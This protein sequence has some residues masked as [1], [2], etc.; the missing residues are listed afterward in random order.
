MAPGSIAMPGRIAAYVSLSGV[1]RR[2]VAPESDLIEDRACDASAA[3]RPEAVRG[4]HDLGAVRQFQAVGRLALYQAVQQWHLLEICPGVVQH[5][6]GLL[7]VHRE[8]EDAR[9]LAGAQQRRVVH[10]GRPCTPLSSEAMESL[11]PRRPATAHSSRTRRSGGSRSATLRNSCTSRAVIGIAERSLQ[12]GAPDVPR[13]AVKPPTEQMGILHRVGD[14]DHAAVP[15]ASLA[16][17]VRA[18]HHQ[19]G[20]PAPSW[21]GWRRWQGSS[22]SW[23]AFRPRPSGR[24]GAAAGRANCDHA[25]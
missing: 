14:G 8:A 1:A 4:D 2:F 7:P 12:D 21:R 9:A 16:L 11:P 24:A 3:H 17:G 5:D 13:W 19:P 10:E 15:R 6:L 18:P 22:A 20:Q 25:K 23:A